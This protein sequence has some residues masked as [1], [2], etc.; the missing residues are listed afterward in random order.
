M[1]KIPIVTTTDAQ[2]NALIT[3]AEPFPRS[4]IAIV[5][6]GTVYTVY[7]EGDVAPQEQ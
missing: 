1:K 2:G 7:E 3:P 4:A 5:C 6:D